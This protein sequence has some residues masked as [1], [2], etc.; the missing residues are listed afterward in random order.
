MG[1]VVLLVLFID[2]VLSLNTT[3]INIAGAILVFSLFAACI[4]K[5]ER[6]FNEK[7]QK[8]QARNINFRPNILLGRLSNLEFRSKSENN[9]LMDKKFWKWGKK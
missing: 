5:A 4:W 2:E 3:P 7:I 8:F 6:I 9:S 1:S